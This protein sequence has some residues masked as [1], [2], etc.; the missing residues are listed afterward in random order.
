MIMNMLGD[1]VNFF[2]IWILFFI[3]GTFAAYYIIGNDLES[4]PGVELGSLSSVSFYI[5]KTLIG[6]Q[7]WDK[8]AAVENELD[9]NQTFHVFSV[10]RSNMLQ[11]LLFFYSIFGNILLLN[12]LIAMM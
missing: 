7:E 4:E 1:I 5:F 3:G 8:T 11:S 12:L 6:Q 10:L 9:P 2:L